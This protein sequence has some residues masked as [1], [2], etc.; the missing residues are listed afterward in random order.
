[1]SGKVFSVLS[2]LVVSGHPAV[3]G[4]QE[5]VVVT[6]AVVVAGAG[7]DEH[8]LLEEGVPL[9]A[10][11]LH[12]CGARGAGRAAAPVRAHPAELGLEGPRTGAAR[13]LEPHGLLGLGSAHTLLSL[14][15][16][17]LL[18]SVAG[19][20]HA[21]ATL[22]FQLA[23]L[24]VVGYAL[25]DAHAA[26]LGALA[27]LRRLDD[28]VIPRALQLLPIGW[29]LAIHCHGCLEGIIPLVLTAHPVL[30]AL[31]WDRDPARRG[32]VGRGQPDVVAAGGHAADLPVHAD[33]LVLAAGLESLAAAVD[34]PSQ[35]T[36]GSFT[37][38]ADASLS[39]AQDAV[40]TVQLLVVVTGL[41][42]RA[43][44]AR[45]PGTHL[46]AATPIQDQAG[47]QWAGGSF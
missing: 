22:L 5:D 8:H 19:A 18:G 40:V 13:Q 7:P 36:R 6:G 1:M 32:A 34:H 39:V 2:V 23:L 47:A 27:P 28:A 43:G 30:T 25:G 31:A 21:H 4:G 14:L 20:D 26:A 44:I 45:L 33:A 29:H 3:V 42:T 38:H 24:V 17:L 12:L 41:Q 10:L 11:E 35:V 46:T 15:D 37:G 9:G 16:A